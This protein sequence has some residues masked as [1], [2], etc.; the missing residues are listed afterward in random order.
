MSLPKIDLPLYELELPST[1]KKV[2]FRPFT[3]KEEKILLTAQESK[4]P[5]QMVMAIKQI[6]NNCLVDY[7]INK[8]S[9]FDL[10]Y[11]LISLRSKSVD[12]MVEFEIDDPETKERVQLE[13]D[14]TKVKVHK[15][16]KHKR[17]IKLDDVYTLYMRYPS[18]D[19]FIE[20]SKKE[21]LTAEENFDI[22]VSCMDQLVS[23]K[24]VFK[25]KDFSKKEVDAFIESLS[26]DVVKEMKVFFDTMPKTRHEI[27][28]KNSKGNE[29]TFVLEGT[30]SFF[31]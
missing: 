12:N 2:K 7:D 5:D 9:V 13:L 31:I 10:E 18:V 8:M 26:S 19:E 1:E 27:K 11:V 14:L 30:Q 4:D 15:D 28:Y 6:I 21:N 23:E 17:T 25:F 3:V 24:D 29:K 22:L 16:P 20:I